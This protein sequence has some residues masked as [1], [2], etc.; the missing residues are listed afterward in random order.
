MKRSLF[1]IFARLLLLLILCAVYAVL[2]S[3]AF[4]PFLSFS[5]GFILLQSFADALVFAG[6]GFLL[7]RAASS[8]YLKLSYYQLFINHLVLG[9]LSIA[10]WLALGYLFSYLLLGPESRDE[11]YAILPA[12]MFIGILMYVL[13]LL[14]VRDLGGKLD[15]ESDDDGEPDPLTPLVHVPENEPLE[16]LD[17]VVTKAGQK[18]HVINVDDIVYI[19]SD[20]DYV[21]LFTDGHRYLKEETMKY[22][23]TYLPPAM[24]VRVHRSYIVN[25]EKILRIELYEKRNQLL[26]LTNGHKIK[27]SVSGYKLLREVLK[28]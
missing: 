9:V 6:I 20:G 4:R 28:L 22:F 12:K 2:Q 15:D 3:W 13:I 25:V 18:I 5:F 7:R 24:F 8:N 14:T 17:R 21:Q 16:P 27:T 19:Q 10:V 23:E 1:E 26:T 11:A